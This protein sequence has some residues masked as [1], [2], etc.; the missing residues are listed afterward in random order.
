MTRYA[1][2][3]TAVAGTP[4]AIH[5]AKGEAIMQFLAFAAAGGK[6]SPSEVEAIIGRAPREIGRAHV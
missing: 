2:I 1:R 6:R 5:P 4:W 3:L